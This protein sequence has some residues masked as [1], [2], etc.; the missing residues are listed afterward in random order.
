MTK[1]LLMTEVVRPRGLGN[2]KNHGIIIVGMPVRAVT[3]TSA[4][5]GMIEMRPSYILDP[6]EAPP[7]SPLPGSG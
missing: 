3:M 4:S 5:H 6:S 1:V 2:R 7:A